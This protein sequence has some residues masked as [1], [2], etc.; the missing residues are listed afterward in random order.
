VADSIGAA[1]RVGLAEQVVAQPDL[2]VGIGSADLLERRA[3]P[4]ADLVGTDPQEG[5]DVLVA[6]AAFE[7]ELEHRALFIGERHGPR[8][9]GERRAR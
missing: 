6:L 2:G 5:A 4:G 3:R 1:D 9:V 8:S 7:Q